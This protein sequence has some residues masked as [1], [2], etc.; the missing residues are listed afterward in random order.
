MEVSTL[1]SGNF[2]ILLSAL[3]KHT[4]GEKKYIFAHPAGKL[5]AS[6]NLALIL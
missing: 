5:S 4:D 3:N 2:Y 6:R 1:W